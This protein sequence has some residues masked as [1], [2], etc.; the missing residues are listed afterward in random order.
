MFF[1]QLSAVRFFPQTLGNDQQA[2]CFDRGEIWPLGSDVAA[3]GPALPLPNFPQN[4][5]DKPVLSCSCEFL[6]LILPESAL[7]FGQLRFQ[8]RLELKVGF[9]LGGQF[10]GTAVDSSALTS[11]MS[12][13]F[14]QG[15][16]RRGARAYPQRKYT[17]VIPLYFSAFTIFRIPI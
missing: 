1:D 4:M 17:L 15:V 14:I 6:G 10:S 13:C 11:T 9:D 12:L 7:H 5:I 2:S 8:I 3:L 16:V